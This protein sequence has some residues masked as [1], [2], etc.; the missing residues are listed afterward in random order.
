[1]ATTDAQFDR[2]LSAIFQA[3]AAEHVHRMQLCMLE[4]EAGT[5]VPAAAN[6]LQILFRATHSLKGAARAVGRADVEAI[7]H[8]ME[9]P[10]AALQR[11][12][13]TWSQTLGDNLY[14][15]VGAVE[16]RIGSGDEAVTSEFTLLLSRLQALEP[17]AAEP[18]GR[19]RGGEPQ[20]PAP[21]LAPALSDAQHERSRED[22]VRIPV[23]HL[24]QL[25]QDVEELV[26][27]RLGV[28][29]R[30]RDAAAVRASLGAQRTA[31]A[32]HGAGFADHERHLAVLR[33]AGQRDRRDLDGA[34]DALLTSIK[35]ALLLPA[36]SIGPFLAATVRELARSQGKEVQLRL[37]GD[38]V[39][40]DR[41]LLQELREP[42]VHLLR[43]GIAHGIETPEVRAHRGKPG[44]GELSVTLEPRAGGRVAITVTDDGAGI[45]TGKLARAARAAGVAVPEVAQRQDLLDLVFGSG[46]ST[47]EELTQVAGRGVGLAI[48]R[49]TVERLGGSVAVHSVLQQG[50]TFR[51]V[52]PLSLATLRVVEVHASG[53]PYLI[54]T[55]QVERCMRYA[56]PDLTTIGNQL[57]APFGEQRVP[58]VSL[59]G[60]LGLAARPAGENLHCLVLRCGER[61]TAV[62]VDEVRAE[63]EVL[64][65][66]VDRELTALPLVSGAA[67][68]ASGATAAILNAAELVRLAAGE[69]RSGAAAVLIAPALPAVRKSVLLA[70]DSITSRTLLKNILEL[71]GY[72]VEVASDG[73]EA[74]E[75]VQRGQFDVVVSDIEMPNLDG[76]DLTRAIRAEPA[77]ARLPV[78]LVTSLASPADR[79]RGAEAGASAYIVKSSFEQGSLLRAIEEL[80]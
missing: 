2:K 3:E 49:E 40:M 74:L 35:K 80:A 38:H 72:Q 5:P 6:V 78:I 10:I 67:L 59:A 70:E 8:A 43:N 22:S 63:Q 15:A 9:S 50:T 64:A 62:A 44:K 11:G 30:L 51:L 20:E 56:A 17:D 27:V 21:E 1:M 68:V 73:V 79:E 48:V 42:L 58:V 53:Q 19:G 39:Q 4:M 33:A 57:T 75:M 12:Q 46:V 23:R 60:L 77:L 37:E 14:E 36:A 69:A 18:S 52:L 47:A 26:A 34:V 24:E 61:I 45:D 28:E 31:A 66:P 16:R 55:A 76:I 54:P 32:P 41:R 25:L 71:A 7:C 65:K 13:L 29:Q